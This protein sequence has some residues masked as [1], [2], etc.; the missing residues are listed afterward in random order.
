MKYL[1]FIALFFSNTVLANDLGKHPDIKQVFD[2]F[3][4]AI[5]DKDKDA[6]LALF[7]PENVS[8][9]G[10]YSD[11]SLAILR[12]RYSKDVFKPK[13]VSSNPADFI[14]NIVNSPFQITEQ[15][16]NVKLTKDNDIATVT[17]DYAY[18]LGEFKSNWG[19]ESWLLVNTDSGW[20][21]SA[22][23][24]SMTYS[25]EPWPEPPT[26]NGD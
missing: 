11:E 15:Y 13:E 20:K 12:S 7:L 23:N 18:Y 3:S 1:V 16:G 5:A 6:F 22:V 24:F 9:V 26:N 10:V 2:T 21:I 17:F 4:T 14:T 19:L 8:W 25:T